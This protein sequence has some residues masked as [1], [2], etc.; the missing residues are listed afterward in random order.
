MTSNN[1]VEEKLVTFLRKASNE[2]RNNAHELHFD[3]QHPQQLYVIC[4]YGTILETII[5]CLTLAK[6]QQL[7][8]IPILLRSVSEAYVDLVNLI[9]DE[10]YPYRM[11]ATFLKE[12][13][14]LL[15]NSLG[16]ESNPF[17]LN[18]S[19]D[20]TEELQESEARLEQLK[21]EG[22]KPIQVLDKFK[23]AGWENEYQSVYWVLCNHSH[24]NISAL[25]SR[26]I[27]KR[28][29]DYEVVLFKDRGLSNPRPYFDVL[30]A[31]LIQSSMLIHKLLESSVEKDIQK[32][33]A[34]FEVL[35]QQ[36]SP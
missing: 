15:K 22:K 33:W 7:M 10:S 25:E 32:L 36:Y 27:E 24:N 13:I 18:V 2:V 16:N 28:G 9:N 3:N 29:E 20:P 11:L 31:I 1:L 19:D 21:K 34:E 26:H 5:S 6:E 23:L 14:R 4:L 8:T 35:R 12:E 17:L 30:N